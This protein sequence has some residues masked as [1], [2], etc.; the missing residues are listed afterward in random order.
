[1]TFVFLTLAYPRSN[2][3]RNLY[4]DLMDELAFRGNEVIVF[5][6]D[7]SKNFGKISVSTRLLVKVVSV[8]VGR[9]TKAPIFFKIINTFLFG[10]RY[11]HAV[12]ESK[13]NAFDVLLYSTPPI[14]L[15]STVER[16]KR[17]TKCQT[18]LLLKDIFP[19]NAVDLRMFKKYSLIWYYFRGVEERLYKVSDQIGCMSPA[20]ALY[21]VRHNPWLD[22]L[23]VHLLPN[24]I[25][26]TNK[27]NLV[28]AD[29][30]LLLEYHIPK[31]NLKLV[32]GG[33]IGKPQDPDF[34][35]SSLKALEN[36]RDVYTIIVGS[37]TEYES[38]RKGLELKKIKNVLLLD[39]LP[40]EQYLKLLS[41]MDVGLI[42]L[43][44]C[45]T[46]P[47][48][49]SRILDYMNQSLP[50]LA[51]TD[52]AS[53]IKQEICDAGAGLWCK[54]ND[55]DTFIK[56]VKFMKDNPDE[57]KRMGIRARNLLE[58]KYT[59]DETASIILDS[60]KRI[61]KSR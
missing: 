10:W 5:R 34:I 36:V 9:I 15:T 43:N 39:C 30:S 33:N 53:D 14:T 2:N 31:D 26:P 46:I 16:I 1:M 57:R 51:A 6:P 42:Y 56:N 20:N 50:I 60:I 22:I 12:I 37:G 48:F 11:L 58:Q 13:V 25:K 24:S 28:T 32:Y 40:K 23:C 49:P 44:S 54:S 61:K 45:F 3:D 8:P 38:L 41:L 52:E 17:R 4:S 29:N 18:Y 59:V 19:Q 55:V 7:E 21:L 27:L 47:N 35:I